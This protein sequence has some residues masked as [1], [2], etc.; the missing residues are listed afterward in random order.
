MGCLTPSARPTLTQR[1]SSRHVIS[2][3]PFFYGESE[4]TNSINVFHYRG[5]FGVGAIRI[6]DP[7]EPQGGQ[8]GPFLFVVLIVLHE[9][10]FKNGQV[11][12]EAK[13]DV[14]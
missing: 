6:L 5:R 14:L 11:L 1:V 3:R 13:S 12:P 8:L 4:I 2:A 9:F 7:A 10:M